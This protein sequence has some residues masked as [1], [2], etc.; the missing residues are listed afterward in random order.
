MSAADPIV[1]N[2]LSPGTSLPD[3][4]ERMDAVRRK[5]IVVVDDDRRLLGTVSDGDI[6]LGLMRRLAMDAPASAVMN[7]DPVA[8]AVAGAETEGMVRL[9][10]R[11]VSLAPLLDSHGRVVG[12]YPDTATATKARD[13]LVVIM[14]GGR[15]VLLAP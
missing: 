2:L 15:G 12:V 4:I 1:G 5:L 3:A 10:E 6:R 11:G 9:S 7:C 8:I 13:N 14:A